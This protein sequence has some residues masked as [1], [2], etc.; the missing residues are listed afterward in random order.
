[1]AIVPYNI[2]L[3]KIKAA[4]E[5]GKKFGLGDIVLMG[6]YKILEIKKTNDKNKMIVHTL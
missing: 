1:M 6:H 4:D 2:N 3:R 5:T